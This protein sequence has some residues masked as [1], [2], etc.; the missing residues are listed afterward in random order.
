MGNNNRYFYDA[1]KLA[2]AAGIVSLQKS[3]GKAWTL[4][5][6]IN[7]FETKEDF[8]FLAYHYH[9]RPQHFDEFLKDKKLDRNEVL[10]TVKSILEQYSIVAARWEHS[11]DKF[12]WQDWTQAEYL[13]VF[14]SDHTYQDTLKKTNNL[15]FR[16]GAAYL[17]NLSP[18][19]ERRIW[20]LIDE[21]TA[22]GRLVKLE[23]V[24][25]LGRS[26]G[27]SVVI[28]FQN[29]A[30][31]IDQY[32]ERL[33]KSILGLCRHKVFFPMDADSAKY[34]SEYI[35]E[36]EYVEETVSE[37]ATSG[38]TTTAKKSKQPTLLQQQLMDTFLTQ[39]GPENGLAGY[40]VAP[41]EG[42]HYWHYP[43][44]EIQAMRAER[45]DDIPR[46]LRVDDESPSL[47]LT[48]WSGEERQRLGL[49]LTSPEQPRTKPNMAPSLRR[50]PQTK[51]KPRK[52]D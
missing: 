18:S 20:V 3:K 7:L 19:S 2:I 30:G 41:G 12:S 10:T 16:F 32:G 45:L 46:Y 31:F 5:D 42:I 51:P 39:P 27:V 22:T 15:L 24:L 14:G 23:S 52:P 11:Q 28:A 29:V 1:A 50:R 4:R 13:A 38:T 48:P 34:A 33:F 47:S 8:R 44:D 43:W 17:N 25:A 6:L 36:H 21:A 26:A 40:F 35:G 49:P 9:P 37:S